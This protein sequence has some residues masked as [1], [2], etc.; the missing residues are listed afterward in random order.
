MLMKRKWW[1]TWSKNLRAIC[2]KTA[3][4]MIFDEPSSALDPLSENVFYE[5]LL[6]A[7][8]NRTSVIITHRLSSLAIV[9]KVL[10]LQDGQVAGYDSLN[11]LLLD[12]EEFKNYYNSQA[13]Y[14]INIL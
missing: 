2:N 14:Y 5:Q 4:L 13:K 3:S 6:S 12:S 8:E 7:L 11:Q 1:R 10:F 9:D